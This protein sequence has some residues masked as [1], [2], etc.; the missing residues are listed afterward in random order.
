MV[1]YALISYPLRDTHPLS[2]AID[3]IVLDASYGKTLREL[4]PIWLSAFFLVEWAV[5]AYLTERIAIS[6]SRS[7]RT[8]YHVRR[9]SPIAGVVANAAAATWTPS[10][11]SPP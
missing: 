8:A 4:G 5:S 9:T 7:T 11:S 1:G 10:I 3:A 6:A 2:T